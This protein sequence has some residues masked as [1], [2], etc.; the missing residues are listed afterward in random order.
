M[1]GGGGGAA[2]GALP[3]PARRGSWGPLGPAVLVWSAKS[4]ARGPGG[5]GITG[6]ISPA[7]PYSLLLGLGHGDTDQLV[8]RPCICWLSVAV[9]QTSSALLA[10]GCR[11]RRKI[12][13][14]VEASGCPQVGEHLPTP[15][16]RGTHVYRCKGTRLWGHTPGGTHMQGHGY[17]SCVDM[18]TPEHV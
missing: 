3:T 10:E 13:P 5:R 16:L 17:P 6:D 9:L 14:E 7:A 4:E 18:G 11:A 8:T 1:E 2:E 12:S 15:A